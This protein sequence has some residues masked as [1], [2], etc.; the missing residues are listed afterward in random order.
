MSVVRNITIYVHLLS[1]SKK[2]GSTMYHLKFIWAIN[3]KSM[4]GV[5]MVGSF[6]GVLKW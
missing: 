3:G 2:N 6:L 1:I 5:K 4:A